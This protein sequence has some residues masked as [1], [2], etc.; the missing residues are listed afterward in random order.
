MYE[1][2]LKKKKKKVPRIPQLSAHA[3][4]IYPLWY[5]DVPSISRDVL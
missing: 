2:A 5:M 3:K 4:V 1:E